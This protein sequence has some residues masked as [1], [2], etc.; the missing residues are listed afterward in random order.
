MFVM[1][2]MFANEK[3]KKCNF[4]VWYANWGFFVIVIVDI[5]TLN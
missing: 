2:L 1:F 5:F 3:I 4:F